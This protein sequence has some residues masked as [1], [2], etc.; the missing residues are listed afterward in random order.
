[1]K[2]KNTCRC[3]CAKDLRISKGWG[4]GGGGNTCRCVCAKD[5][6]TDKQWGG[7]GVGGGGVEEIPAG[8]YVQKTCGRISNGGGGGWRK[9]LQVCMCKKYLQ[10]CMC[11][12]SMG[13]GG[14][15]RPRREGEMSIGYI[16]ECLQVCTWKGTK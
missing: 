13:G 11:K 14:G 4:G 2:G 12:R 10:V 3:V 5:L 8:V 1:M 7:G 6:R 9:Y 15:K 16:V